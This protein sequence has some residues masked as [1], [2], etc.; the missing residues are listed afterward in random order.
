MFII[1]FCSAYIIIITLPCVTA[2]LLNLDLSF[3]FF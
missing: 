2:N 3:R 1:S